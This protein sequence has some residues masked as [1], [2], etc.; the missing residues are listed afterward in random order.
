MHRLILLC[1]H[2]LAACVAIWGPSQQAEPWLF[3]SN[4]LESCNGTVLQWF[5]AAPS[6]T[7]AVGAEVLTVTTV[8][9]EP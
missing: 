8:L 2:A 1:M 7:A 5:W 3:C 6:A 9:R 4:M